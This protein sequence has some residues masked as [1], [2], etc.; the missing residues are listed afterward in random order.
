MMRDH[1][2]PKAPKR[3]SIPI[4][5]RALLPAEAA[6]PTVPA[7]GL[8]ITCRCPAGAFSTAILIL[9]LC[10]LAIGLLAQWHVKRV[11]A[12][13]SRTPLQS[14]YTGAEAALAILRQAGITNVRIVEHEELLGDHYDPKRKQL[15]LSSANYHGT[16][17][18]LFLKLVQDSTVLRSPVAMPLLF[19]LGTAL[20]LRPPSALAALSWE[21]TSL[22]SSL[23]FLIFILSRPEILPACCGL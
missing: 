2:K 20:P 22:S 12:R 21:R 3:G 13:H 6:R 5:T 14:G 16:S 4:Q 8:T 11:Y 23:F 1:T 7:A 15:V 19:G 17:A 18:A 10:T 9:F